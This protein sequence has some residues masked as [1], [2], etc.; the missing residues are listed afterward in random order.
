[1]S[2]FTLHT[3]GS[4]YLRPTA[5]ACGIRIK[6]VVPVRWHGVYTLLTRMLRCVIQV[7][8]F[9]SNDRFGYFY[10]RPYYVV[11]LIK[12]TPH[13]I[14]VFFFFV[15]SFVPFSISA[16]SASAIPSSSLQLGQTTYST[17]SYT[18]FI[19]RTYVRTYVRYWLV[20][21]VLYIHGWRSSVLF[22]LFYKFGSAWEQA[23]LPPD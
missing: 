22:Y 3:P 9:V 19:R 21:M 6:Q 2:S 1:M 18:L 20:A 5:N 15:C 16:V 13:F 11:H 7:M 12:R 10:M 8:E 4:V 17:A 14:S 23:S